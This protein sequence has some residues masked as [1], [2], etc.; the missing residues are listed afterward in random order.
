MMEQSRISI[1]ET[2]EYLGRHVMGDGPHYLIFSPERYEKFKKLDS[3]TDIL[4]GIEI[5]A[6]R[7]FFKLSKPK[8]RLDHNDTPMDKSWVKK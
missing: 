3:S 2:K 7:D 8:I 1:Y 5:V 4:I 6:K